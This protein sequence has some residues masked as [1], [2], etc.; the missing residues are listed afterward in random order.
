MSGLWVRLYTEIKNDRK[1][2]RLPPAR[3]WLWITMLCIAKDSSRQGWLLV[4]KGVPANSVDLAD[5]AD[6]P[7]DEVEAGLSDFVEL[8]MLEK[9]DGV[10]HLLNWDKRQYVSDSSQERVQRHR[11]KK[12]AS[13]ASPGRHGAAYVDDDEIKA[14][15]DIF[16]HELGR[17]LSPTETRQVK[18]WTEEHGE[19]LV[20]MA[21][22]R[23]VI[24]DKP[25][26]RYIKGV[27]AKWAKNNV[28]TVQ[29]IVAYE[30]DYQ[31]R[32]ELVASR[33][34][35]QGSGSGRQKVKPGYRPSEEDWE[36]EPDTL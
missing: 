6:I 12:K 14:L 33:R 25:Q 4:G 26:M 10:W 3:R 16:E 27:L 13:A 31:A 7:L 18:S 5:E 32:K 15:I 24:Q 20:L 2:R 17:P 21:L 1:L 28:R 36:N 29:E 23:A 22:E 35:G 34:Y 9:V 8:R 30:A 11:E 19:Q